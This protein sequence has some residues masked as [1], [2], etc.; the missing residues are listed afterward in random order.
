MHNHAAETRA[1]FESLVAER[2][3]ILACFSTSGEWDYL[4]HIIVPDIASYERL[5]MDGLLRHPG[6]SQSSSHFALKRIK[7]TTALPVP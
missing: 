4:L 6:V 7:Y 3:E 2:E 1:T 5:L